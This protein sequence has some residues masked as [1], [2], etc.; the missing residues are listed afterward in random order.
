MKTSHRGFTFVELLTGIAIA[1][2]LVAVAAPS[3]GNLVASNKLA[4]TANQ[5][6][7]ASQR[8]RLLAVSRNTTVS[9][10]AGNPDQGCHGDWSQAQWMTFVD[11]DADG[12]FDS[13]EELYEGAT[14]PRLRAMQLSA[15]GPF[16]RSILFRP[17][18][19]A[20]WPSGA[21]AAGRLRLC[22]L[23]SDLAGREIVLIGSGRTVLEKRDFDGQCPAL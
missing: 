14:L 10:C 19:N 23:D 8:A 3:Y 11:R 20:T 1:V 4:I 21:F 18:G 16:K 13:T 2:T 9:F 12:R 6:L 7:G 15:N 17:G 5:L 22:V